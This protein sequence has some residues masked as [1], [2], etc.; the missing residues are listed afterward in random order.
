MSTY[1]DNLKWRYATKKFDASKKISDKDLKTLLEAIQLSPSSYGLQPYHVFVITDPK[2]RQQLQP[3]SWNQ[4]QIVDASHLIVFASKTTID[5]DFI[6]E[7]ITNVSRTRNIQFTSLS[8]Y[9]YFIKSKVL[10]A[11]PAEQAI[12][13]E[14]QNYLALGNFLSATASLRIDSCPME[15]FD[16]EAYNEILGL[17]EKGLQATVIAAIGYRADDDETQHYTKVRQDEEK[18]FTHL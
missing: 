10:P 1:L 15:G 16:T 4:T 5:E 8:G 12:W 18:L 6:D 17:K 7:Y 3:V 14:K 9:S 13:A 2:I 11:T